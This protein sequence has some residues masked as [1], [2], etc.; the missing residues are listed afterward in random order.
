MSYVDP[1]SFIRILAKAVAANSDRR[2]TFVISSIRSSYQ[3]ILGSHSLVLLVPTLFTHHQVKA[4]RKG[5]GW[6]ALGRYSARTH[7]QYFTTGKPTPSSACWTLT[8]FAVTLQLRKHRSVAFRWEAYV[9]P[10]STVRI[11]F[12]Y[13]DW[14]LSLEFVLE[15]A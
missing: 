6:A 9:V 12:G 14:M 13:L 11:N 2:G 1:S 15:I 7:K 8:S 10:A 4:F 5:T 3:E